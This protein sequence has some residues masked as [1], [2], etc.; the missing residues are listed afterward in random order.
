MT[1]NYCD[2]CGVEII[3]NEYVRI[4]FMGNIEKFIYKNQYFCGKCCIALDKVI[5]KF[6][7][8]ESQKSKN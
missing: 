1:K 8:K 3:N 4:S 5:N 2:N 6:L 7:K